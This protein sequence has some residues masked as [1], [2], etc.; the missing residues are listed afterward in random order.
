MFKIYH[1]VSKRIYTVYAV[2]GVRFVV[3]EPEKQ[4]WLWLPMTECE[5]VEE[6]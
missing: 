5:P 4:L 2:A 6:E 1:K 3:W